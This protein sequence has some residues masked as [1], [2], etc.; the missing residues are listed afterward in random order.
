MRLWAKNPIEYYEKSLKIR[1]EK[2]GPDHSLTKIT[3]EN[4]K[5]VILKKS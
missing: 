2:L 3:E 4:L 5:K 1:L